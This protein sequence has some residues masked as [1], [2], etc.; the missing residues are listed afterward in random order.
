MSTGS[1]EDLR[2]RSVRFIFLF[3]VLVIGADLV[4]LGAKDLCHSS[5]RIHRIS[6]RRGNYRKS[7]IC[8]GHSEKVGGSEFFS[9]T[10]QRFVVL[11]KSASIAEHQISAFSYHRPETH[12]HGRFSLYSLFPLRYTRP[13]AE[14]I[15]L[16][17]TNC[18][19]E[20]HQAS[21]QVRQ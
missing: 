2:R 4:L 13:I 20:A 17:I 12:P 16:A 7:H 3:L 1:H 21:K 8:F 10:G 11:R 5:R 15:P 6:G 14:A 18:S 9:S 19:F